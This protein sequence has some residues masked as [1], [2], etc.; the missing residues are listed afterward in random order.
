MF[1]YKVVIRTVNAFV[2]FFSYIVV[3]S[4]I[5]E[6]GQILIITQKKDFL[7]VAVNVKIVLHRE[8]QTK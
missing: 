6:I 2:G 3:V 1:D 4:P 7:R 5:I 8:M